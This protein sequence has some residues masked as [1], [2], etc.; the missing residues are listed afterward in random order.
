MMDVRGAIAPLLL[1]IDVL[2]KVLDFAAVFLV[3]GLGG[4]AGYWSGVLLFKK[5]REAALAD[6]RLDRAV[7][8]LLG[9]LEDCQVASNHYQLA[10]LCQE[11]IDRR[12]S[13]RSEGGKT[14]EHEE[15]VDTRALENHVAEFYRVYMLSRSMVFRAHLNLQDPSLWQKCLEMMTI[16][17]ERIGD[18]RQGVPEGSDP[19]RDR[20]DAHH[21]QLLAFADWLSQYMEKGSATRKLR[22]HIPG[23]R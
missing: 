20:L 18:P 10:R 22:N 9:V 15:D 8:A 7:E 19:R 17:D 3:A 5:K 1:E 23:V 2:D 6:A 21:R 12:R 13:I 14:N 16:R 4:L 11:R